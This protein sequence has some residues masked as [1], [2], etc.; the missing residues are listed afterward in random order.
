MYGDFG[1]SFSNTYTLPVLKVY[2]YGLDQP[3]DLNVAQF[4]VAIKIAKSMCMC[5]AY[6][7]T[8][9]ELLWHHL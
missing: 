9:V 6:F 7:S 8:F 4:G 1:L 3:Y 5:K 2:R